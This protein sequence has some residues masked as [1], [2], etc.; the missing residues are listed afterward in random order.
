MKL[1][2]VLPLIEEH[3]LKNRGMDICSSTSEVNGHVL[4]YYNIIYTF[5]Q[6]K[7]GVA[8]WIYLRSTLQ[9]ENFE[10][11]QIM[12]RILFLLHEILGLKYRLF[13]IPR[14]VLSFHL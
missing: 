14:H 8:N 12:R 3:V 4:I 1:Y 10:G 11:L 7:H 6:L 13:L 9:L 5:H 2:T